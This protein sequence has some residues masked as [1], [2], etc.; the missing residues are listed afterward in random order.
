[1]TEEQIKIFSEQIET[2]Y[3]N[4]EWSHK[5]HEKAADIF[6][7]ICN[8]KGWLDLVLSFIVGW[9]VLSQMR[10]DSPIISLLLV[11]CS[12]LLAF[13]QSVSKAFNFEKRRDEHIATAKSLWELRETYRSFKTDIVAGLYNVE[14]FINKRDELQHVT[15]EIYKHA[16]RTFDWAYKKA[17]K[18]FKKWESNN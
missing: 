8:W 5:I 10:A 15:S 18:E 4:V 17:D 16:P 12:G 9:E 11:S 3:D 14:I 2:C 13:S 1:M 7:I 6:S